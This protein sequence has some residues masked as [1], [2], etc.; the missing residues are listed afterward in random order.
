[1]RSFDSTSSKTSTTSHLALLI[2]TGTEGT[3]TSHGLLGLLESKPN[4]YFAELMQTKYQ[5]NKM[6]EGVFEEAH[7][8][9][10]LSRLTTSMQ[11]TDKI[12]GFWN[13]AIKGFSLHKSLLFQFIL[14]SKI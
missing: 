7:S 4:W 5:N 3:F 2:H 12:A 13:I 1:M 14:M 10:F 11:A 6:F 8:S 9:F